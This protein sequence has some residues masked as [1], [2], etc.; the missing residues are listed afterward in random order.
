MSVHVSYDNSVERSVH[1]SFSVPSL[2]EMKNCNRLVPVMVDG[3]GI[4]EHWFF[5]SSVTG[6]TVA[7]MNVGY[8][9]DA[10][11][12]NVIMLFD[13]EVHE[14]H[15]G[16]G[17]AKEVLANI[18]WEKKLPIVHTD[19]SYTPLGA[20]RIAKFFHTGNSD[21][22][23]YPKPSSNPLVFVKDWENMIPLFL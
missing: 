7:Y 13:I 6:E 3:N 9:K 23:H 1:K 4:N 18:S 11:G 21:T 19:G 16:M 20:E 14:S 22:V 10:N 5:L 2:E 17:Y 15:R 12:H 8:D